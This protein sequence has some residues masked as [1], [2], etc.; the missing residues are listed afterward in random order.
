MRRLIIAAV[1]LAAAA[2]AAAQ[3]LYDPDWVAREAEL[4]AQ[5]DMLRNR[6]IDLQ[7]QVTALEMRLQADRAARDLEAQIRRPA[8]PAPVERDDARS[9]SADLGS[10]TSI[11]DNRL[12]A[13]NDRVRA[14]SRPAR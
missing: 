5:Q 8:L 6:S 7:N 10:F 1:V 13:S 12:D 11:P 2:P 4:R 9:S 3:G 14:A